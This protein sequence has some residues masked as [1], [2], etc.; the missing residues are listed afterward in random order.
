MNISR[1]LSYTFLYSYMCDVRKTRENE[2]IGS[3]IVTNKTN[4]VSCYFEKKIELSLIFLVL[5]SFALENPFN[6]IFKKILRN[7][8]GFN[9]ISFSRIEVKALRY[10]VCV[11]TLMRGWVM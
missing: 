7:I 2:K 10:G 5:F 4:F 1:F 9:V 3:R 8:M 11:N 6:S